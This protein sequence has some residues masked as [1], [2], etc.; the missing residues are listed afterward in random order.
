MIGGG[1]RSG[2]R[3]D[4]AGRSRLMPG[5]RP[6]PAEDGSRGFDCPMIETEEE[7]GEKKYKG[8]CGENLE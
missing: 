1:D 4:G 6:R 7:V 2:D 8:D 3:F 5:S